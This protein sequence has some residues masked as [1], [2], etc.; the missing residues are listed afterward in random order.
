MN[1]GG[2]GNVCASGTGN[3]E[4]H[5]YGNSFLLCPNIFSQGF[6]SEREREREQ[7]AMGRREGRGE[8]LKGGRDGERGTSWRVTWRVTSWEGKGVDLQMS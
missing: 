2:G 6:M 3:S 5:S 4:V 7:K 8:S 1:N